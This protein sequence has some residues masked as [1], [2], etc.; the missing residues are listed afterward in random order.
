MPRKDQ[1][2]VV[3][4]LDQVIEDYGR[5]RRKGGNQGTK[6]DREVVAETISRFFGARLRVGS[7]VV[8]DCSEGRYGR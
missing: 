5:R 7:S 3:K 6:S 8:S 4:F 2:F 1:Q